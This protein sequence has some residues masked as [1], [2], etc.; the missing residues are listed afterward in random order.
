LKCNISHKKNEKYKT[1][2]GK[3]EKK[4]EL[5]NPW[6]ESLC[7]KWGSPIMLELKIRCELFKCQK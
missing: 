3:N 2:H 6:N 5:E 1:S 4:N 7:F